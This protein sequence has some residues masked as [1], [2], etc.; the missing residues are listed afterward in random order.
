MKCKY[1]N[2]D[3]E[4]DAQFCTNCGKDLSKFERCVNCGELLDRDTVFCPYCGTE[5]SKK[6]EVNEQN[7][8]QDSLQE[9]QP[10]VV[11]DTQQSNEGKSSKKWIWAVIA[12]VLLAIIGGGAY[13]ATNGGFGSIA[14]A[15]AVDSDSIAV[16]DPSDTDVHSIDGIKA[17]LNEILIQ[18]QTMS[19]ENSVNT[20]F[21]NE[22]KNLY[23][24]VEEYD[25][26]LDGPGFWNGN[27][28]DGGQDGNPDMFE[29]V[30]VSISSPSLALAEVNCKYQKGEYKAENKINLVLVFENDNWVIDNIDG[31]KE[32][33][34]E[35]INENNSR[36]LV[37]IDMLRRLSVN[38][39]MQQQGYDKVTIA[40]R[41]GSET[42]I[43]FRNCTIGNRGEIK[44]KSNMA[45]VVETFDGMAA[46]VRITV[47]DKK[48][49]ELIKSEVL[50]YSVKSD[51]KY[52]FK[53]DDNEEP[54]NSA[55]NMGVS[56]WR[57]GG[58]Y[59]DIP[60]Y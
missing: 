9:S 22:F 51:S 33:M 15:E 35:Y 37:S 30:G 6:N 52:C 60:L 44:T 23:K 57:E 5:Q 47:F 36:P 20:F 25:A 53:W 2:A 14:M 11:D 40:G 55:I 7:E 38:E 21:S 17:R 4:Q 42:D 26:T 59:I 34:K 31:N 12:V 28:W 29:I 45:C 8:H 46:S 18:S 56:E 39:A 49:Y 41:A 3:I 48:E 24:K 32:Q 19:D 13:F 10:E 58:F 1:C 43:W 54:T 50:K 16:I 27:L